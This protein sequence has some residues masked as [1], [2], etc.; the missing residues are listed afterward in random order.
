MTT[1]VEVE[2]PLSLFAEGIAGRYFHIRDLSERNDKSLEDGING[3][4]EGL[5]GFLNGVAYAQTILADFV[6]PIREPLAT[7]YTSV[8]A[9]IHCYR[10][11]AHLVETATDHVDDLTGTDDGPPMEWLQRQVRLED[12]QDD[13]KHGS[14]VYKYVVEPI[15]VS[16]VRPT[17]GSTVDANARNAMWLQ[18]F[19]STYLHPLTI[20]SIKLQSLHRQRITPMHRPRSI[21]ATPTQKTTNLTSI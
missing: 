21:S 20:P 17:N 3:V 14:G 1:L 11:L 13:L 19:W 5:R 9:T 6:A 18:R 8:Q 10:A 16:A 15:F 12:W 4:L 7:V 2:R